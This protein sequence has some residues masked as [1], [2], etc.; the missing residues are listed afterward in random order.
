MDPDLVFA[1]LRDGGFEQNSI[2][3]AIRAEDWTLL[4]H[5]GVVSVPL[6]PPCAPKRR[7]V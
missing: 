3:A 6:Q 2:K 7:E 5:R 1:L 4:R